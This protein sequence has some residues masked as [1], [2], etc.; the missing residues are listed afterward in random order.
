V[1]LR[2]LALQ[3]RVLVGVVV[4]VKHRSQH[5]NSTELHREAKKEPVLIRECNLTKFSTLIVN[6]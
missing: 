5:M 1:V 2:W 3:H 4:S 6:E